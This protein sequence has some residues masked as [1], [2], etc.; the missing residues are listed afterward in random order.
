[1]NRSRRTVLR[2]GSVA[3]LGTGAGCVS[4]LREDSA[5]PDESNG[6]GDDPGENDGDDQPAVEMA[7]DGWPSFQGSPG[8]TGNAGSTAAPTTEP[9]E[10]WR[11]T[12]PGAVTDQV[13]VVDGTVSA[14]TDAG[15]IH[16]LEANSGDERWSTTVDGGRSQC[17]CVVDGRVV[18]GTESGSL[19]ALDLE[20]GDEVWTADLSGPVMGPTAADGTVYVGTRGEPAVHAV[21]AASGDVSWTFE[22]EPAFDVVNYPAVTDDHVF[23]GTE[24]VIEARFHALDRRKETEEWMREVTR[25]GPPTVSG[26]LV[27]VPSTTVRIYQHDGFPRGG[28]SGRGSNAASPAVSS[29]AYF[30]GSTGG[31]FSAYKRDDVGVHWG[32]DLE[33]PVASAPAI[34][35]DAVYVAL[36]TGIL[37]AMSRES[38][39]TLWTRS[40]E[41]EDASGPAVAEGAVFVGTDAGRLVAFE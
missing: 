2:A 1:M 23:V 4:S 5:E 29:D 27:A 13:A 6:G 40:L 26:S 28:F 20:S 35:D 11:V 37:R 39:E 3:L 38:G 9:T 16:A 8:N 32:I 12:L 22:P 36:E 30:T 33:H 25:A 21:D 18:V 14:S 31:R 7:S 41:G 15:T 17:P 34:T 24:A 19:V 10:R